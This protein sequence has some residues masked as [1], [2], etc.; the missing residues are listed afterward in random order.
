MNCHDNSNKISCHVC[1]HEMPIP[2]VI[3]CLSWF[4]ARS[5][6]RKGSWS[7]VL[8]PVLLSAFGTLIEDDRCNLR[9]AMR[10]LMMRNL[11]SSY[12][13]QSRTSSGKHAVCS[14]TPLSCICVRT[15]TEQ[16]GLVCCTTP[17]T[18][19]LLHEMPIV[20][21]PCPPDHTHMN[22]CVNMHSGPHPHA[23]SK[24]A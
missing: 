22:T 2:W 19:H 1:A 18:S 7:H 9:D 20:L 5:D 17:I 3:T 8:R 24:M 4:S 14:I 10:G 23:Y 6:E 16:P 15:C 11:R 12:E 21:S 13:Q